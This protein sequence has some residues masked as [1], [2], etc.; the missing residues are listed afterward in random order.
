MRLASVSKAYDGD[1]AL[2]L[3]GRDLLATSST[4]GQILPTL[5]PGWSEVTLAELL[6]HTGGSPTT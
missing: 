2:A 6:Q 3:V 1:I 4:I 5:A